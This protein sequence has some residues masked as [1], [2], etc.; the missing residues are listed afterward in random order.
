[1]IF[2]Y[3]SHISDGYREQHNEGIRLL[4]ALVSENFGLDITENDMMKTSDGKPFFEKIPLKFSIAHTKGLAVCGVTS[5]E[6]GEIGIDCEYKRAYSERVAKRVFSENER[7]I[8][9]GSDDA[10]SMFTRLWTCKESRVKYTGSGL[11]GRCG[12]DEIYISDGIFRCAD[13]T[14]FYTKSIGDEIV[15][16]CSPLFP[17]DKN[18]IFRCADPI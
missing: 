15:T 13:G 18:F 3:Y 2:V 10:D 4:K 11:S 14:F 8:I 7:R 9:V 17:D 1:M 16:V 6:N 5:A 12:G